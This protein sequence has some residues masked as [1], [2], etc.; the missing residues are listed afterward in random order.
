MLPSPCPTQGADK[1][2]PTSPLS[3]T[4]EVSRQT[5]ASQQGA[6]EWHPSRFLARDHGGEGT[7][8]SEK[9]STGESPGAASGS[10]DNAGRG[11]RLAF[12]SRW[13]KAPF[14]GCA[15][16]WGSRRKWHKHQGWVRATPHKGLP[17][18]SLTAVLKALALAGVFW[19]VAREGIAEKGT[20]CNRMFSQKG[21]RQKLCHCFDF[22]SSTPPP[23]MKMDPKVGKNFE[24]AVSNWLSLFWMSYLEVLII[25]LGMSTFSGCLS[26][27][28]S[29]M[30]TF[31][32]DC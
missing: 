14:H 26:L 28:P 3:C 15:L 18:T 32:T 10:E 22:L 30:L 16:G 2:V 31:Q 9:E 13:P 5:S 19:V 29:L 24:H 17:P 25:A 8:E 6:L 11:P 20:R 21:L 7:Q 4:T 27:S 1:T 12:S 23:G